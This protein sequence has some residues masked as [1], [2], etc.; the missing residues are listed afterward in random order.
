MIN[1]FLCGKNRKK[2]TYMTK[3]KPNG[4]TTQQST[5]HNN[6][7]KEWVKRILPNKW[8]VSS[9]LLLYTDKLEKKKLPND[10]FILIWSLV[11]VVFYAFYIPNTLL[12]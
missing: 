12:T 8:L 11:I 5:E 3:H 1:E 10:L 6:K 7:I 9:A 2:M 4:M